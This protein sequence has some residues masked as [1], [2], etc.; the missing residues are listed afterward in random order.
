MEASVTT[1]DVE[2]RNPSGLHARPAATFVK[3]ASAFSSRIRLENL[4]SGRPAG[5]AKSIL[6]LLA[7]GVSMGHRVR[8]T[9]EGVDE[10]EAVDALRALIEGGLGEAPTT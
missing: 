1:A 9:A 8:I 3:A 4:T 10:A 6:G 2:V 7:C 5:D